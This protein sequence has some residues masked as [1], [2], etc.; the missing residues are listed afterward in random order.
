MNEY[1]AWDSYVGAP[2]PPPAPGQALASPLSW[3]TLGHDLSGAAHD[4]GAL[5]SGPPPAETLSAAAETVRTQ[6]SS[7]GDQAKRTLGTAE[8]A[9]KQ[10]ARAAKETAD[11]MKAVKFVAMGIGALATV[12]LLVHILKETQ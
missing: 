7:V 5:F 12:A 10:I 9:Q 3:E 2:M 4:L 1:Y 8:S 6:A 11:T